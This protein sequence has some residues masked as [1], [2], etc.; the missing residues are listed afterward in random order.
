[1]HEEL[2]S[3]LFEAATLSLSMRRNADSTIYAWQ[4]HPAPGT[5]Y[6][7]EIMRSLDREEGMREEEQVR[8]KM[9]LEVVVMG[10]WPSCVAYSPPKLGEGV[11]SVDAEDED[12]D[13]EERGMQVVG[14]ADVLVMWGAP[15]KPLSVERDDWLGPSLRAVVERRNERRDREE[16]NAVLGSGLAIGAS[17]A[18]GWVFQQPWVVDTVRGFI[19]V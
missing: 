1:M 2:T 16:R 3:I 15:V 11:G 14:R 4:T 8:E 5:M 17:L 9:D 10:G 7:E 18:V 13:E 19:G 12:K 6:D